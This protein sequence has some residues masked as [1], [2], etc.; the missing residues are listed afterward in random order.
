MEDL[1]RFEQWMKYPPHGKRSKSPLTVKEYLGSAR[2]YLD[3]LDGGE[4]NEETVREFMQELEATNGPRS[5]GRHIQAL[6]AFFASKGVELDMGQPRFIE[7]LQRSLRQEEEMKLVDAIEASVTNKSFPERTT[8]WP[9]SPRERAYFERAVM[10]VLLGSGVRVS[11]ACALRVE[12]VD[13]RG[14]LRVVWKGGREGIVPVEDIVITAIQD[15]IAERGKLKESPWVFPGLNP[16]RHIT[17][18]PIQELVKRVAK[19]AGLEGVHAHTLRHSTA[20]G[21]LRVGA[22]LRQVQQ[23][24]G[25]RNIQTTSAYTHSAQAELRRRLPKRFSRHQ[26]R[27]LPLEAGA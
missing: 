9:M 27:R 26:Q 1:E 12:S 22:S 18:R 15:W 23:V 25:H 4:V 10:W 11:E 13:S 17:T 2:R 19:R 14:Y 3:H 24:L 5:I 16:E 8:E 20:V 7:K 6:R 21:L